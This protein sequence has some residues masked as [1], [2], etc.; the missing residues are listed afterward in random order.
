MRSSNIH[1]IHAVLPIKGAADILSFG[2]ALCVE[3]VFAIGHVRML[4]RFVF[5]AFLCKFDEFDACC[6][7]GMRPIKRTL[8]VC[9]AAGNLV[10][11]VRRRD[12][13]NKRSDK[14]SWECIQSSCQKQNLLRFPFPFHFIWAV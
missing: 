12:W 1:K 3:L 9:N 2:I 14:V 4:K 6:A 7:N 5:G 13:A 11:E 10:E 8:G